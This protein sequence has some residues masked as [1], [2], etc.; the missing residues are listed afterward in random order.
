[1]AKT[2]LS[3]QELHAL[4]RKYTTDMSVSLTTLA[5]AK[6]AELNRRVDRKVLSAELRALGYARTRAQVAE[7]KKVIG[8]LRQDAI[9]DADY[10]KVQAKVEEVFGTVESYVAQMASGETSIA[11]AADVTG[12]GVYYARKVLLDAGGEIPPASADD[13]YVDSLKRVA[14][15]GWDTEAL[16]TVFNDPEFNRADLLAELQAVDPSI[17]EKRFGKMLNHLGLRMTEEQIRHAQ[18]RRSRAMLADGLAAV[19]D[20]GYTPESLAKLYDDD[21]S[22]RFVDLY[23]LVASKTDLSI[24]ERQIIRYVSPLTTSTTR[25]REEHNFA[26]WLESATEHEIVRN[27]RKVLQGKE[28]DFIIPELGLAIEFNGDYWH[29]NRFMLV[30]HNCTAKEYHRRKL[31]NA[32][33]AGLT[34]LFVWESDWAKSRSKV[35]EALSNVLTGGEV[36]DLLSKLEGTSSKQIKSDARYIQSLESAES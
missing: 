3:E 33:K 24:T 11:R 20:A 29:S 2:G 32:A 1:M 34:L 36:P 14:E 25:S 17:T 10:A 7:S 5:D 23:E 27:D 13:T 28:L 4:G 31:G 18:G 16:T 30:N 21:F 15:H 9:T 19:E 26:K 35:T 22:V 12:V 8:R 6:A